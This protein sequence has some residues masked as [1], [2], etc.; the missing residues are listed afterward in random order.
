[1]ACACA[2][3]AL[4]FAASPLAQ[5][6][7]PA[8]P[9]LRH[10]RGRLQGTPTAPVPEPEAAA[11]PAGKIETTS[12]YDPERLARELTLFET[13]PEVP[14]AVAD[15]LAEV[16][17]E[18]WQTNPRVISAMAAVE[19]AGYEIAGARSG[20][21]PF[22]AFDAAQGDSGAS[23]A[24]VRVVQ[25]LWRGGLTGAQV[26]EAKAKRRVALAELNLARLEL[27]L[28]TAEAYLNVA[29]SKEQGHRW[30]QYIKGLESL[31]QVI[32]RRAL[33]GVSPPVDVET[34]L[35]RLRAARAGARANAA[36]QAANRSQLAALL[37]RPPGV[38]VWPRPATSLQPGEI[39]TILAAGVVTL[40]PERQR[41]LAEVQVAEAQVEVAKASLWPSISLQ[42]A[43]QLEQETGDF[44]PDHSTQLVFQYQTDS[45]IKGYRS[46]QAQVQ[47]VEAARRQLD[48]VHLDIANRIRTAR[49]QRRA[50]AA[51]YD[52]QAA[53][54]LS[55]VR[56]VDSF[57]RQF[58]VGRKSWVEV[59]N[60]QR[61]AHQALL[62]TVLVKRSF[63]LANAQ[64]A[65]QGMLW[66]A[67]APDAPPVYIEPWEGE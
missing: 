44:T 22:L 37:Q 63:W 56:L 41:A 7:A 5:D 43:R 13:Q 54:A 3:A 57:L 28:Q 45:G 10:E 36:E 53:S 42:H 19:A 6:E 8:G 47:R 65:L 20:Y 67:I 4:L 50:A 60:A 66:P 52:A 49:V 40:H 48:F 31:T 39:D 23:T 25:P 24:T 34:A 15:R 17:A 33:L 2:L 51:Q 59:L 21:F 16:L 35:A 14:P 38:V 61:E 64:L 58:K 46:Y 55:F 11:A 26:A 27:G 62:Q 1:M 29:A 18:V 32:E 12:I 9:E 30:D